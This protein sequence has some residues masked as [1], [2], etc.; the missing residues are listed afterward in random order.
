M[1][2]KTHLAQKN[3]QK[4]DEKSRKTLPREGG[5]TKEKEKQFGKRNTKK[6]VRAQSHCVRKHTQ[7]RNRYRLKIAQ[8]NAHYVTLKNLLYYVKMKFFDV[9]EMPEMN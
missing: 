7:F 2:K 8:P 6:C 4:K 5:E 1:E 3:R 9:D